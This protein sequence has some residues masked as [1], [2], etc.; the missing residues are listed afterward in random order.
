MK[1]KTGAVILAAGTSDISKTEMLKT[2]LDTLRE[3]GISPIAVVTGHEEE[4][5]RKELAHRK[6]IF[7]ENPR[8][9]TTRMFTSIQLGVEALRGLC[10]KALIV[11]ADSPS[12]SAATA[13]TLSESSQE[14]SFPM[15]EGKPGHPFCIHMDKV[16]AILDYDGERGI[17]GMMKKNLIK[18]GLVEVK[19]PGI[20]LEA[21][22]EESLAKVLKYQQDLIMSEPVRAE[23][24]LCLARSDVFFD[25]D[26]E[27]LLREIDECH[28]MNMACSNLNMAYSRG[29]KMIKKAEEKLGCSLI[30]KQ[31]GGSRGGGSALTED[32]RK[33]LEN[34]EK[35]RKETVAFAE[36]MVKDYFC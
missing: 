25:E 20:H 23:L 7:V 31:T 29:W 13:V 15:H 5:I 27:A 11:N 10:D 4:I 24:R 12:F 6:V 30:A 9:R 28:S 34:Y 21:K 8:Y 19:D 16:D 32:G 3:A 22:E 14:L 36:K 18:A 35:I 17:Q 1:N 2:E 33:H 26:L